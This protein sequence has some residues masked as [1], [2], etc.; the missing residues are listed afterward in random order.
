[1]GEQAQQPTPKIVLGGDTVQLMVDVLQTTGDFANGVA[2]Q[3]E[4]VEAGV[5]QLVDAAVKEGSVKEEDRDAILQDWK[6]HPEKALEFGTK[7][8]GRPSVPVMGTADKSA[9]AGSTSADGSP[10]KASDA[11]YFQNMGAVR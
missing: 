11:F 6:A 5:E 4:A 9:A 3:A 7:L 2:K 8:V 1:M 10:L